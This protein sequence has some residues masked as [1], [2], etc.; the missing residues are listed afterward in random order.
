[1]PEDDEQ[2]LVG[3][4][5]A[6]V[7]R[8]G[9]TVRRT[10]G[11]A[12]GTVQAFLTELINRGCDQV[13]RPL[14]FDEQGREVWPYVDGRAGH[15]PITADLASDEALINAATTIR[16]LHDLSVGYHGEGWSTA[17]ADPSG[18]AEVV[19]HNDLA[20]FNL[21][22][23]GRHVVA[24]IDWD[25]AA[26]GRRVWDLAYAVWRLV[27]L[28]RPAYAEPLGWSDGL[29][30][31]R[32]LALFASAYGMNL[33]DREDLLEVVRE[34]QELN[35][36]GMAKLAERGRIESLPPTD[37]RAESGDLDYLDEQADRWRAVLLE[38]PDNG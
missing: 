5:S 37:P 17:F 31:T 2:D 21:I 6:D 33:A 8:V 28:H 36:R 32:R 23:R 26:P 29:D 19:C 14:G 15:P 35:L 13:P 4:V 20:P 27:P 1:M 22:F 30:R 9:Q 24:V 11:P 38:H 16:R 10:A 34:R 12:S 18:V 25:G 3:G 7:V